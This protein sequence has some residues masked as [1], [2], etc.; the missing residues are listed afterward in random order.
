MTSDDTKPAVLSAARLAEIRERARLGTLPHVDE[1][2]A[3]LDALA[4]GEVPDGEALAAADRVLRVAATAGIPEFEVDAA[5]VI[6]ALRSKERAHEEGRAAGRAEG[7][8]E[9]ARPDFAADAMALTLAAEQ[10]IRGWLRAHG[11]DPDARPWD[12]TTIGL[13][14]A[15]PPGTVAA[16]LARV[17]AE[18]VPDRS[19][20]RDY[21]RGLNKAADIIRATLTPSPLD[22]VVAEVCAHRYATEV[23]PLD[24]REGTIEDLARGLDSAASDEEARNMMVEIAA[25]AFG[26]IG[27]FDA[28]KGGA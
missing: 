22:G 8:A 7:E 1:L 10:S 15:P 19:T 9:R 25:L 2:L 14:S 24:V 21:T 11:H 27:A 26:W 23:G 20:W 18:A 12:E 5:R 16:L 28:A 6:F 4:A 17:E 13:L 3:H